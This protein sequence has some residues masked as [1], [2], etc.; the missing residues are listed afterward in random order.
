MVRLHNRAATV[1]DN[2]GVSYKNKCTLTIDPTIVPLG[3]Y[4]KE[5][6]TYVHTE[7]RTQT[8]IAALFV[9]AKL[10]SNQDILQEVNG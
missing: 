6:G 5:Q 10:G 3:I 7:T 8:F 9:A 1:A 2:L 4:P